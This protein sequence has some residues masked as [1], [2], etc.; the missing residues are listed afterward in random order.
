MR[1]AVTPATCPQQCAQACAADNRCQAWS[2]VR[3]GYP[4]EGCYLKDSQPRPTANPCCDSGTFTRVIDRRPGDGGVPA[5]NWTAW[6]SRDDPGE[7]A[8]YEDLASVRGSVPCA[9]PIGIECRVVAPD[10]R[11]WRQAGQRYSCS[12][13]ASV[14]GGICLNAENNGRCLNYE[15][16]YQCP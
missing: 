8:D 7:S 15:V 14:P 10:L 2:F 4:D 5:G 11:D 12:L 6:F 16:R 9:Q 13:Q 1:Y 3:S